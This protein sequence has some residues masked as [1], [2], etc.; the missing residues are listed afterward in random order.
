VNTIKISFDEFV[1][2]LNDLSLV[3]LPDLSSL[4]E[5]KTGYVVDT[6]VTNLLAFHPS[7]PITVTFS[8]EYKSG[9]IILQDK[10][11]CIPANLL[12]VKSGANVLDACAAPGNKTTQ[13]AAAVGRDGHVFAVEKDPIRATTLK[14]M[15]ERA[16][17]SECI[18]L[19]PLF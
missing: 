6:T 2:T 9:S 18:L 17:A 16:G 8:Q 1:R 11:S 10:A 3:P 13:L 4:S 19:N 12:A 7:Y 5:I 15:V 14:N